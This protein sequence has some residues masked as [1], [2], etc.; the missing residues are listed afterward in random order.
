MTDCTLTLEPEIHLQ[1]QRPGNESDIPN[2]TFIDKCWEYQPQNLVKQ[3]NKQVV[4]FL[5]T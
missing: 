1:S 2:L 5:F 3:T 4:R